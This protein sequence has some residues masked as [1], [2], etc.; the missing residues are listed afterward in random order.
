VDT[1]YLCD[2][3]VQTTGAGT[4]FLVDQLCRIAVLRRCGLL[5]QTE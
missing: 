3:L 2:L 1:V 4:T 5:L